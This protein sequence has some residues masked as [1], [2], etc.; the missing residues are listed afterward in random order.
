MVKVVEPAFVGALPPLYAIAGVSPFEQVPL[1]V[2]ALPLNVPPPS[3][4]VATACALLIEY[5]PLAGVMEKLP[6]PVPVTFGAMTVVP[7]FGP[8][9]SGE[10]VHERSPT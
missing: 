4:A 1:A 5:E 7:T 9:D 3:T 10:F 2:N 6:S 8:T